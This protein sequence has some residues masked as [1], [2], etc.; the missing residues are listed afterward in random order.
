MPISFS[1]NPEIQR[2]IAY[3]GIP[4]GVDTSGNTNVR[5]KLKVDLGSLGDMLIFS[6][7]LKALAAKLAPLETG[8][9]VIYNPE[10]YDERGPDFPAGFLESNG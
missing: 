6:G 3:I 7:F 8:P 10:D 5:V 2:G 9:I 1:T 4:T